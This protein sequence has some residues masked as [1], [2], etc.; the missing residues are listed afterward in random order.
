MKRPIFFVSNGWTR[1]VPIAGSTFFSDSSIPE[2]IP[3]RPVGKVIAH[4]GGDYKRWPD[5]MKCGPDV[6]FLIS[7]KVVTD[8][9][10]IGIAVEVGEVELECCV[11]PVVP[12]PKYFYLCLLPGVEFDM[13]AA[14]R[15]WTPPIKPDSWT[16]ADLCATIPRSGHVVCSFRVMQLAREC[17]WRNFQFKTPVGL[18]KGVPDPLRMIDYLAPKRDWPPA[19]LKENFECT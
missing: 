19:W 14:R 13:P 5:A 16:G 6:P 1:G 8:L 10:D 2:G 11:G 17:K 3:E 9:H 12:P 4:T 7:E 15:G 18:L